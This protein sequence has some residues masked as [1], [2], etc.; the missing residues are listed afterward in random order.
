MILLELVPKEQEALLLLAKQITDDFPQIHGINIPDV[1]RLLLRSHDAA[2]ALLSAYPGYTIVPHSRS[3][4]RTLEKSISLIETLVRKGLKQVLIVKGDTPLNPSDDIFP[5]SPLDLISECREAFPD[6]KIYAAL[7]PYRTSFRE[8]LAYCHDKIKA[9]A[10]GFFSQPFFDPDLA[11]IY[12]EQLEGSSLFIGISPVTTEKSRNYWLT[13]NNVFFPKNF[14]IRFE[15]Q[16][17][18][19]Q[20]MIALTK[21]LNQHNYLMPITIDVYTYIKQVFSKPLY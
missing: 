13:R 17:E 7:D 6:L 12:I 1:K 4:D 5:I 3:M 10:D 11:R 9:G 19:T 8:E 20:Q 18:L 21:K 16:V 2:Y 14:D 15:A